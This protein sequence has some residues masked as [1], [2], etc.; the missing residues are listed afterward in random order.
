ML[1]NCCTAIPETIS[2]FMICI[3]LVKTFTFSGTS[4]KV[5]NLLV[6]F[7]SAFNEAKIFCTDYLLRQEFDLS[8]YLNKYLKTEHE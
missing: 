6:Y 2:D 4:S 5:N 3:S 7:W 8:Q 1:P